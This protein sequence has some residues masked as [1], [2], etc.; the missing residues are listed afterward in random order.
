MTGLL[1]HGRLPAYHT[2]TAKASTA[3]I[4]ISALLMFAHVCSWPF[5]VAVL[6]L[7][8]SAAE[9]T[10]ISLVLPEWR[11]NIGSLFQALALR[12]DVKL[13]WRRRKE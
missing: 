12:D 13:P 3:A 11:P 7:A 1:R 5:R 10:G 9:E 2:W 6:L 8:I 4:G